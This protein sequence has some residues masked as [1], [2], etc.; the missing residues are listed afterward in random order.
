MEESVFIVTP[1]FIRRHEPAGRET[2]SRVFYLEHKAHPPLWRL[3]DAHAK[4]QQ[5]L[6]CFESNTNASLSH[7][8]PQVFNRIDFSYLCALK[9]SNK[10]YFVSSCGTVAYLVAG[11]FNY[12]PYTNINLHI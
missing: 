5:S 12:K 11:R 6:G 1:H 3:R 2:C 4:T 9:C 7:L 8:N 10:L